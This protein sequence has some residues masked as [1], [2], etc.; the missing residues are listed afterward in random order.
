MPRKTKNTRRGNLEGS[1]YQRKDGKWC[2]QVLIGY[3][4]DGKPHRKTFYGKTREDVAKKITNVSSD[5]F[6]GV[7]FVEPQNMTMRELIKSW[8]FD[9]KKSEVTARTFEW[10][11]NIAKTYIYEDLGGF[12]ICKL[13]TYHIQMLL[14]KRINEGLSLRT[15]KAV[16]NIINQAIK[17]ACEMKI[18]AVNPVLGTKLPKYERVVKEDKVKAIPVELRKQILNAAQ[19]DAIMKPIIFTLMFT[20]IRIGE[21]LALPWKNVDFKTGI[22]IIDRAITNEVEYDNDGEVDSRSTIVAVTKTYSGNRKIKMPDVLIKI[23]REWYTSQKLKNIAFISG[24]S[25]V[26]ANKFG[27]RRTYYGFRTNYRRFMERNGFEEHNINIHSYRHTFATMLLEAG[28]NP[29][30]VQ[31]LLGHKD[32][33]TTLGIYSHVLSEVYESTAN[34]VDEIY[35]NLKCVG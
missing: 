17:H 8:L 11:L 3:K 23:L 20:G 2:G 7:P 29:K 33:Q 27:E 25:E 28:V 19:N 6:K 26:F 5:N 15:V 31:K 12:P 10:Y 22:I 35:H 34:K 16:R 21:L 32:V 4:P 13:T 14:N 30:V 1:I 24:N 9:F 18:L